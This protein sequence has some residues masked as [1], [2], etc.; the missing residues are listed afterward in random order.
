[1]SN[2]NFDWNEFNEQARDV[3]RLRLQR[4]Q[5]ELLEDI[6]SGESKKP[7]YAEKRRRESASADT[8]QGVTV[9]ILLAIGGIIYLFVH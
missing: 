4:E 6:A 3:E 5:N 8:V 2:S 7:G 1:M 9:L